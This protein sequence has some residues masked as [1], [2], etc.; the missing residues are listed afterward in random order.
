MCQ[1]R[2]STEPQFT[3]STLHTSR[4]RINGRVNIRKSGQNDSHQLLTIVSVVY[5]LY[6]V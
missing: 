1:V 3:D 2:P 5:A 4:R 6:V